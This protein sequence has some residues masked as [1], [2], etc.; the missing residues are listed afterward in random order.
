MTYNGFT[1]T[2][3]RGLWI[4]TDR[5]VVVAE[6]SKDFVFSVIDSLT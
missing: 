3:S 6:G 2:C 5:G 1:L 4:A